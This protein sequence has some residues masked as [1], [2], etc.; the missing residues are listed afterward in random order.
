MQVVRSGQPAQQ[1]NSGGRTDAMVALLRQRRT[2]SSYLQKG[3][4]DM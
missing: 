2:Y 1:R 3:P 4:A